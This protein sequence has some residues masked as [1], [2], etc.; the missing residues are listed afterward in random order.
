MFDDIMN[1]DLDNNFMDNDGD[2]ETETMEFDMPESKKIKVKN[3]S[4][5][6]IIHGTDEEKIIV[7]TTFRINEH[8]SNKNINLDVEVKTA[9]DGTITLISKL[10]KDDEE[11]QKF[12]WENFF[13]SLMKLIGKFAKRI[14][15]SIDYEI[16]LPND[17]HI[18]C[19]TPNGR[20]EIDNFKGKAELKTMN[21]RIVMK[22]TEGEFFVQSYNGRIVGERIKGKVNAET[23]NGR[24]VVTEG[25]LSK[26]NAKTMNGR[27]MAQLKPDE[28]GKYNLKTMNGRIVIAIPKES[29]INLNCKTVC[30]KIVD[31][32]SEEV[33]S[34]MSHNATSNIKIGEGKAILNVETMR[35]NIYVMDYDEFAEEE[36]DNILN[37][38]KEEGFTRK[39]PKKLYKW[40]HKWGNHNSE[41][42]KMIL[43]MVKE[44][45]ITSEEGERLISAVK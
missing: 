28:E 7:K 42:I 6:I 16:W 2:Y 19:I 9:E 26:L 15:A 14:N 8:F 21:G 12:D 4:G 11:Y 34:L 29:S 35:G 27:I 37:D 32:I 24:I 30:G 23:H 13:A 20:Y 38:G 17:M 44:G 1:G 18:M 39:G 25:D 5:N 22:D 45:K 3:F 40:H 41:E 10:N 43:E 33:I 36:I 31:R